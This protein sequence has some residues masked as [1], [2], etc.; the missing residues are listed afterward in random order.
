MTESTITFRLEHFDGAGQIRGHRGVQCDG[1]TSHLPDGDP[2][3]TRSLAVKN[4]SRK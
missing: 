2:T 3:E 4:L 1:D